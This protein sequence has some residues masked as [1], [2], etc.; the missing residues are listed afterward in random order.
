MKKDMKDHLK[1]LSVKEL[2]KKLEELNTERTKLETDMMHTN[3]SSKLIRNY[4]TEK[5]QGAYGNVR[6]VK[7]NMARIKTWLN[8]KLSNG[9]KNERHKKRKK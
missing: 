8:I 7:K 3:G 1:S 6:E 4:P 9:N 5:Y 2:Q